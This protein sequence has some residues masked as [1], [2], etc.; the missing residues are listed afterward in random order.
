MKINFR[1]LFSTL[2]NAQLAPRPFLLKILENNY[3]PII[4]KTAWRIV[5]VFKNDFG[6]GFIRGFEKLFANERIKLTLSIN[7]NNYFI[8]SQH[9][10]QVML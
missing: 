5:I 8:K 4:C 9:S 6:L 7:L 1:K 10:R 2:L 3:H